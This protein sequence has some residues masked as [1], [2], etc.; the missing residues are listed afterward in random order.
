MCASPCRNNLA[1]AKSYAVTFGPAPMSQ[2]QVTGLAPGKYEAGTA[3]LPMK[4]YTVARD[5]VLNGYLGQRIT[6]SGDVVEDNPVS[7]EKGY[8]WCT[9]K[10]CYKSGFKCISMTEG[11][12]SLVTF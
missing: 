5:G 7:T 9:P 11:N 8:A 6:K 10:N 12:C 3:D 1:T 4:T 2:F